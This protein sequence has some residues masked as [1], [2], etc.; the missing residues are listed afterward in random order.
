MPQAVVLESYQDVLRAGP[1][2]YVAQSGSGAYFPLLALIEA[3]IATFEGETF[4]KQGHIVTARIANNGSRARA[5]ENPTAGQPEAP[6]RRSI[7]IG[8]EFF[9]TA[10]KDYNDWPLKWWREAVQNAVDAGGL[11]I[12]LGSQRNSD[13]TYTVWCD[14]DG[15][16]MDEDIIINKFLVLGAT[17]KVLGGTAGG[18]GKAKELL[19]LPWISWKVHSRSTLVSGAGIDYQVSQTASRAGTRLEVVMPADRFTDGAVAIGFVGKCYLPGVRFTVSINGEKQTAKAKLGGGEEVLEIVDKAKLNFIKLKKGEKQPYIYVR[20]HGLFMFS[21][22]VGDIPGY[23]VADLT[24]PSVELLTANRDGFRDRG[25]SQAVSQFGE[26]LAKDTISALASKKLLRRK[27]KGT[28]KFRAVQRAATLL[29]QIGP[30]QKGALPQQD[31]DN[32][33]VAL[34]EYAKQEQATTQAERLVA[35]PSREIAEAMLDQKFAG[36]SHIEAALKQLVWE[37]DFYLIN[38]IDDFTVPKKFFPE[39]MTP[40]VLKL[41]KVW[42]ELCRYVLMQL[43]NDRR[44]GVGFIFSTSIAAAAQ[45]EKDEDTEEMAAW[46]FL[47]PFTD[48][49]EQKTIWRTREEDLK[50]LYAA[51]IHECTHIADA[52]GDH[53]EY[54]AAAL[55]RN[56]AKCADGYRKIRAIAAGIKMRGAPELEREEEP[57]ARPAAPPAAPPV[58]ALPKNIFGERDLLR[59]IAERDRDNLSTYV[60]ETPEAANILQ[61]SGL[62]TLMGPLGEQYARL[63]ENGKRVAFLLSKQIA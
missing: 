20:T 61:S 62:I 11:N 15:R 46:L 31:K 28:G 7:T 48:M 36:P 9:I 50:W 55:T 21:Y 63:T 60:S 27:Y 19:L 35:L 12:E 40:T 25:L 4:T 5:Q 49:Y 8:P 29:E 37:P 22:W 47:N 1:G 6:Q 45:M 42:A 52:L 32:V 56:M 16:G 54:F 44:F 10:L 24:G 38:N 13:G 58:S 59:R 34:D 30:T 2:L 39:T 57:V 3:R 18:F 33:V 41:A 43:G 23:L 51:A 26:K 53:D 17:T 14:D